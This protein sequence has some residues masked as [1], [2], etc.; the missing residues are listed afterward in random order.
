MSSMG[1]LELLKETKLTE[2]QQELV[3]MIFSSNSVL[4]VLVEDILQLVKIDNESKQE[5]GGKMVPK[6]TFNLCDCLKELKNYS[7]GYASQFSVRLNF[8]IDGVA[9]VFVHSSVSRLHQILS[10][11]L[12]NAIKAS[13]ENGNVELHCSLGES[14]DS[15]HTNFVFKVK[16]YGCGIPENKFQ[17]IFEPFIQLHNGNESTV[18][19]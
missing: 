16:D 17:E 5:E 6:E 7:T 19:R 3:D 1:S 9:D 12:T 15:Y 11:L 18:P 2:R 13:K 14:V 8:A 10:N 4:L